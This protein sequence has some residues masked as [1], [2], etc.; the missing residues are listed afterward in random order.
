MMEV[1]LRGRY[2]KCLAETLHNDMF[3]LNLPS[4]LALDRAIWKRKIHVA[5]TK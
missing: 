2:K 5:Y 3:V 1:F 4:L